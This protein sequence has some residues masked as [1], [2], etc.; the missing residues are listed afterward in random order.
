MRYLKYALALVLVLLGHFIFDAIYEIARPKGVDIIWASEL[1]KEQNRIVRAAS[2]AFMKSDFAALEQQLD[3]S[4]TVLMNDGLPQIMQVYYGIDMAMNNSLN[5]SE[6]ED[7]CRQW[8]AAYPNSAAARV[9]LAR[10]QLNHA[11]EVRGD[12][13]GI[14]MTPENR[15]AYIALLTKGFEILEKSGDL[16]KSNPVWHSTHI[17]IIGSRYGAGPE[18]Q[19]ASALAAAQHPGFLWHYFVSFNYLLPQWGGSVDD[20]ETFANWAATEGDLAAGDM[21]YAR[22]YARLTE[23]G[24]PYRYNLFTATHAN[25]PRIRKG[26]EEI[27]RRWPDAVNRNRF[28]MMACTQGDREAAAAQ[29]HEIGAQPLDEVWDK[30][31]VRFIRCKSWTAVEQT[32]KLSVPITDP[33]GSFEYNLQTTA[34][35]FH[36]RNWDELEKRHADW[37]RSDRRYNNGSAWLDTYYTA[38]SSVTSSNMIGGPSYWT[39]L[40]TALDGWQKAYPASYLPRLMHASVYFNE[41][42][43]ILG[44]NDI[45][46]LT[47]AITPEAKSNIDALVAKARTELEAI[48]EQAKNDPFWYALMLNVARSQ[49]WPTR[50]MEELALKG[51]A[52]RPQSE[53]F[54]QAVDVLQERQGKGMAAFVERIARTSQQAATSAEADLTY[55]RIYIWAFRRYFHTQIFTNSEAKWADLRTGL[56]SL[57]NEYPHNWY[58]NVFAELACLARDPA[59]AKEQLGRLRRP[60][61]DAW[62]GGKA[63]YDAC[64][65]WAAD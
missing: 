58:R 10:L 33:I 37:M 23:P 47:K 31:I 43:L 2:H 4:K 17:N 45:S 46:G 9:V 1:K 34:G 3:A 35:L 50:E 63:G 62:Q 12:G 49:N 42:H 52:A 39:N 38:L 54:M 61:M 55:A 18:L 24:N 21:L 64:V 29:L 19:Q 6:L 27:V 13:P 57:L 25:W 40:H 51:A 59:T 7:I 65:S 48:A 36:E 5:W 20:L 26:Y 41:G 44:N 60:N 53:F 56:T 28:A 16:A 14:A 22:L 8:Q 11:R 30:P 15:S 32:D